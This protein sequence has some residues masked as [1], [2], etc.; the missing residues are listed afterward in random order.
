MVSEMM[1]VGSPSAMKRSTA[2]CGG[3]GTAIS[4]MFSAAMRPVNRFVCATFTG[5]LP[6]CGFALSRDFT[7]LS[8]AQGARRRVGI[9][10]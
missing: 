2:P 9:A 1:P 3:R 4:L 5:T 7:C 6:L 10:C 8:R